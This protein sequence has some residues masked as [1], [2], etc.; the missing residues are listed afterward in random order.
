MQ[1]SRALVLSVAFAMLPS[2]AQ[3]QAKAGSPTPAPAKPGAK[4]KAPAEKA[5][6]AKEEPVVE[7]TA[8][9]E[10]GGKPR[11]VTLVPRRKDKCG[12]TGDR[13]NTPL[14]VTEASAGSG[15]D[16]QSRVATALL[17]SGQ[18][19]WSDLKDCEG[20]NVTTRVVAL[21]GPKSD[22]LKYW[23]KVV[24]QVAGMMKGIVHDDEVAALEKIARDGKW[25]ARHTKQGLVLEFPIAIDG[26]RLAATLQ[27]RDDMTVLTLVQESS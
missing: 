22:D 24:A 27:D 12:L 20:Y 10:P 1:L 18:Y 8:P 13:A 23:L 26:V 25:F 7:E 9:V 19:V 4:E 11:M 2:L 5:P 17:K 6:P 21:N 15:W 14:L 3:A 16:P